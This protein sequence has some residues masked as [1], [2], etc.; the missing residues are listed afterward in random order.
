[1]RWTGVRRPDVGA[2]RCAACHGPEGQGLVGPNLTDEYWLHG[3]K[4]AEIRHT[5]E[6]GVPDKGMVPWKDQLKPEEIEALWLYVL[7]G[8]RG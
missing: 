2:T 1:M 3:Q 7:A 5:I 6:V 4:L 8:E